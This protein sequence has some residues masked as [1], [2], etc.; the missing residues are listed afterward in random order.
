ME[1]N[2]YTSLCAA[3]LAA[4][5]SSAPVM[6]QPEGPTCKVEVNVVV[7]AP[8]C[9]ET[10]G[11]VIFN[12]SDGIAPYLF[13]LNGVQVV[14]ELYGV[15]EG[16][17]TYYVVDQEGCD[18][19][20]EFV[21]GCNGSCEYRTQTM[22]GW[23]APPQGNNPGAYLHANF[24]AAFPGGLTVGC[25]RVLNLTTA[26]AVTDFL[27]SGSS[28][29]KLQNAVYTNPGGSYKNVLAGQL[30][31]ATLSVTFDAYDADFAASEGAFGDLEIANGTFAG[32]TVSELLA[33]ANAFIGNCASPYSASQLNSA[34]TMVNESFVD[35]GEQMN[36]YLICNG[37]IAPKSLTVI[38]DAHAAVSLYPV[39]AQNAMQLVVNTKE[40]M[41]LLRIMDTSGRLIADLGQQQLVDGSNLIGVDVS[42]LQNGMYLVV[43]ELEGS[44]MVERFMVQR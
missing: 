5:L 40:G 11:V 16:V 43:L 42:T 8:T 3:L 13:Y 27:P 28:P 6:A 32:M 7:T 10:N 9:G 30:V 17:Y 41:S 12:A 22:G 2:A 29:K 33:I 35:G 15:G 34:L 38:E 14:G 1:L 24:A 19:S 18:T 23:G 20:G 31:A 26:Q 25:N 39:P 37:Y 21:L 36:D 4:T 44:R